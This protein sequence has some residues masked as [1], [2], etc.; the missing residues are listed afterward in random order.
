M[1]PFLA[2]VE[3]NYTSYQNNSVA[4]S[5]K[6]KQDVRWNEL[7]N[8]YTVKKIVRSTMSNGEPVTLDPNVPLQFQRT[9]LNNS[10]QNVGLFALVWG[11]KPNTN[12]RNLVS[13]PLDQVD[14]LNFPHGNYEMK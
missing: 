8:L 11:N 2:W 9:T 13:I 14:P 4:V 6:S 10:G 12:P 5:N 3:N 7:P 1:K